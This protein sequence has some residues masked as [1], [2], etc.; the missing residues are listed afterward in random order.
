MD[1]NPP[2]AA[3]PQPGPASPCVPPILVESPHQSAETDRPECQTNKSHLSIAFLMFNHLWNHHLPTPLPSYSH[4]TVITQSSGPQENA[5]F[6]SF[7]TPSRGGHLS[8]WAW[9]AARWCDP[10]GSS[11]QCWVRSPAMGAS[12]RREKS[13]PRMV[14]WSTVSRSVTANHGEPLK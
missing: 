12:S 3:Q 13:V 14:R 6:S 9:P 1:S 10:S 7:S 5:T 2:W 11:L 8:T 4:H